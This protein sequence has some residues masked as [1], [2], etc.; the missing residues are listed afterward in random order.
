MAA[1]VT[2]ISVN[3]ECTE[4]NVTLSGRELNLYENVLPVS[5][6][7]VGDKFQLYQGKLESELMTVLNYIDE[8][9]GGVKIEKEFNREIATGASG[10]NY[11]NLNCAEISVDKKATLN[12]SG[13]LH[14]HRTAVKSPAAF[15]SELLQNVVSLR[16]LS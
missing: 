11:Y 5:L 3:P 14:G 12:F 1:M 10:K 13:L 9:S 8:D 15:W 2:G 16:F 4:F 6:C 7:I